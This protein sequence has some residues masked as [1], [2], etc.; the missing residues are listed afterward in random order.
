MV[1]APW[2]PQSDSAGMEVPFSVSGA[3]ATGMMVERR[4]MKESMDMLGC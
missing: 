2:L 1:Q 3:E 4:E